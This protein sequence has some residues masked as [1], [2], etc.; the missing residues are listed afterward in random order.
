MAEKNDVLL[1][2]CKQSTFISSINFYNK[3]FI[4]KLINLIVLVLLI[5]PGQEYTAAWIQTFE[6]RANFIL[7][8]VNESVDIKNKSITQKLKK[9]NK[10]VL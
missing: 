3:V 1:S 6:K 4:I 5:E 7:I 8:S 9:K 10:I 2:I